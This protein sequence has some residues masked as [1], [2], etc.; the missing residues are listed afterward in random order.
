MQAIGVE[1]STSEVDQ[2]FRTQVISVL[3]KGIYGDQ[4][5]QMPQTLY[6]L[7]Q[8]AAEEGAECITHIRFM[9]VPSQDQP[10]VM[11]MAAYGTISLH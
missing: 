9:M 5:L 11:F 1:T 7:Q 3:N 4:G 10:G 2:G 8:K 6:L